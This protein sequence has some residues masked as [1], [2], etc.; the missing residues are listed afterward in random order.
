MKVKSFLLEDL[1]CFEL[2]KTEKSFVVGGTRTPSDPNTSP[3]LGDDKDPPPPSLLQPIPP[4]PP[5]PPPV[6]NP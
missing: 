6:L 4:P 2:S 3:P 1:K 5:P